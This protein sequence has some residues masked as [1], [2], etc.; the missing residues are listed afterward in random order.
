[1][2]MR[3]KISLL[4]IVCL[5][6]SMVFL[7]SNTYAEDQSSQIITIPDANLEKAIRENLGKMDGDITVEDM[8]SLEYLSASSRGISN[9]EGLQYAVN[10]FSLYVPNNNISDIS[11]LSDLP[12]LRYLYLSN[13]PISNVSIIADMKNLE[14]LDL[15]SVRISDIGFLSNLTNLRS[16]YLYNNNISDISVLSNLTNLRYLGLS[17]NPVINVGIIANMTNLE[18]L[19][20]SSVGISDISFLS[21]LT[22]LRSVYLSANNIRDISVLPNFPH[23]TSLGLSHNPINDISPITYM[24]NLESLNLAYLGISDISFLKD[25]T[26]LRYLSLNG[27]KISDI[28][29]LENLIN[30]E[31]LILS[32]NRIT[33]I[34]P[35]SGLINNLKYLNISQNF[36]DLTQN[37]QLINSIAQKIGDSFIYQP[38]KQS[39]GTDLNKVVDI[40]DKNLE[41]AIR[42]ELRKPQGDIVVED[43]I[44]LINLSAYQKNIEDLEGLQYALNLRSLGLWGNKVSDIGVLENLSKLEWV[45]L[46]YNNISDISVFLSLPNLKYLYLDNNP[47]T[48]KTLIF[49]LTNL[50]GLGI[51]SW[52]I[53]DISF[54]SNFSDLE[55]LNISYNN[56]TDISVVSKFENLR[57]LHID[58]NPVSG[59]ENVVGNLTN[60]NILG[61]GS[62]KIND[63]SFLNNLTNLISLNLQNNN[64]QD[65]SVLA[66]LPVLETVILANNNI[67]DINVFGSLKNISRLFLY[68]NK[69][70]DISPL[71]GLINNLKF[72]D[73]S[74][75]YVD[76]DK[77]QELINSFKAK[78]GS[79]FVYEPQFL[80]P[81]G[82]DDEAVHI[83]DKN[84]ESAIREA[85][86]KPAGNITVGDMANLTGLYAEAKNIQSLEGLQYAVNIEILSLNNNNIENIEPLK[87]LDKI[88]KLEIKF[89]KLD[90]KNEQTIEHINYFKDKLGD[91]FVYLPQIKDISDLEDI[92]DA[93][94][95]GFAY[96]RFSVKINRDKLPQNVKNFSKI[97]VIGI[98]DWS[99]YSLE[100]IIQEFEVT[101]A[102]IADYYESGHWYYDE[103][104]YYVVCLYDDNFN[105][106]GYAV[107]DMQVE[108][109]PVLT[110]GEE[111][112]GGAGKYRTIYIGGQIFEGEPKYLTVQFTEGEGEN[113]K[114]SVIVTAANCSE[115]NVSYQNP[116]TKVEVW[117]T[118]GMPNLAGNDL[119]VEVLAHA[120]TDLPAGGNTNE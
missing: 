66:D 116:G 9:L 61:L 104:P 71:A 21:N 31:L 5:L 82:N 6:F 12:N 33:D 75:N 96:G 48:D 17:N 59:F 113:A 114:V 77:N 41:S 99:L 57:S 51:S 78:L 14:G 97:N 20:L 26:N 32:D 105:T 63:I 29:I 60:L 69:I 73:I 28:S 118:D 8:E 103:T 80:I 79:N 10:L 11:V 108:R 111:K 23:L 30:I 24:T 70:S 107:L 92:K 95:I 101:H 50:K 68:R 27:N 35:L 19:D 36:I 18:H 98:D 3:R 87:E 91:N 39:P 34:S 83:S 120:S 13:N 52:G 58:G 94:V 40:P 49:S 93:V 84:L 90:L 22:N 100:G 64:L 102:G 38:Q 85:L 109:V 81:G 76:L 43:M 117:L 15:N 89:N 55:N 88:K 7:G 106:I 25:F 56:I 2:E 1:M 72:L 16:L 44:S 67:S 46:G 37:Q 47:V 112:D 4:L 110:I 74:Q 53:D 54:L 119:G 45:N 42:Q 86:E 62:L 65:I 115:I